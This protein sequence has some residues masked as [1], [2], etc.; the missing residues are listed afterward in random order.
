MTP[1]RA[2]SG[3]RQARG[4]L[5][6]LALLLLTF[7]AFA[8][9]QGNAVL[10]VLTV[11]LVGLTLLVL[12]A[13][14]RTSRPVLGGVAI[15][16]GAAVVVSVVASV[17][18]TTA[19]TVSTLSLTA[20]LAL[21]APPAIVRDLRSRPR[22]SAATVLGALCIYLLGGLLFGAV[23]GVVDALSAGPFFQQVETARPVDFLY[24]SF[25]TLGTL[26]YGD[27]TP[28]GDLG[29]MLAVTETMLGQLYLV[30][31]VAILVSNIGFERR[32]RPSS[33]EESER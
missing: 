32:R 11:G 7:V 30:G 1:D 4:Y 12:L 28:V 10:R 13:V 31:V 21:L 24:F 6:G 9:A 22:I 33:D 27:L 25:V 2:A 5:L 3:A 8:A 15:A 19:G 17:S 18:G 16:C 20:A 23:F 14:S 29:R 26:G